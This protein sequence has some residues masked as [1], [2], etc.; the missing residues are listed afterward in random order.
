MTRPSNTIKKAKTVRQLTVHDTPEHNSV[1]E[2]L[3]WTLLEKIWAMLHESD[4]QKFLWAEAVAH[5]V[6]LRNRTWTHTIG[7]TTT[8]FELLD[9]QKPNIGIRGSSAMGLQD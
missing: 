8:P 2:H 1:A 4:L 7:E 6:Y 5:A 9:Q 3:N